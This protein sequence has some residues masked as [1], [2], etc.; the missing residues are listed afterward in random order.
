M[1]SFG[2]C[3]VPSVLGTSLELGD[4]VEGCVVGAKISEGLPVATF[5]PPRARSDR[6]QVSPNGAWDGG[7][8]RCLD[9]QGGWCRSTSYR[10]VWVPRMMET[11]GVSSV[12]QGKT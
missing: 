10:S 4:G 5:V 7:K 8:P 12:I 11:L 6:H 1:S 9:G 3:R 2:I